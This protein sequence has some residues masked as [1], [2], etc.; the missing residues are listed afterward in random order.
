M[1]N[2]S[3]LHDYKQKYPFLDIVYIMDGDEK[4]HYIA[5]QDVPRNTK[6]TDTRYW[7]P[8]DIT[9]NDPDYANIRNKPT[10]NGVEVDGEM[11]SED[12]GVYSKP[13]NGIPES[14]LAPE[15]QTQ[16]NKHFKGWYDSEDNLPDNPMVGDY[17]YV[18]G[19]TAEDPVDIYE[20][21]MEGTW[22][23]SG[24][25]I[26]TSNVQTFQTGEAVNDVD[27]DDTHLSNTV[28][29]SLAKA[30]D[31]MPLKDKLQDITTEYV[32]V[33]PVTDGNEQNVFDGYVLVKSTNYPLTIPKI[34]VSSNCRHIVI[35]VEGYNS[36]RFL[37]R[38]TNNNNSDAGWAFYDSSNYSN[39]SFLTDNTGY[40]TY[41]LFD[42]DTTLSSATTKEYIVKIPENAKYLKLCYEF[43][44]ITPTNFY[45]YL[46]KGD[47]VVGKDY[48]DNI[49]VELQN[50]IDDIVGKDEK[51]YEIDNIINDTYFYTS[52]L[53]GM[54]YN[55]SSSSENGYSYDYSIGSIITKDV[56][57]NLKAEGYESIVITTNRSYNCYVTFL[58]KYKPSADKTVKELFEQGYL[59]SIHEE[60]NKPVI[61]YPNNKTIEIN[62]PKDCRYIFFT[63]KVYGVDSSSVNRLPTKITLVKHEHIDGVIDEINKRIY[64]L[65]SSTNELIIEH[66][67]LDNKGKVIEDA[68]K[69][70]TGFIPHS[71]GF[72]IELQDGY[73]VEKAMLYDTQGNLVNNLYYSMRSAFTTF[74]GNAKMLLQF[75]VRLVIS[76]SDNATIDTTAVV[77]RYFIL[78]DS[79]FHRTIPT[80]LRYKEMMYRLNQLENV[81]WYNE[82]S[83]NYITSNYYA[84]ATWV[85]IPYSEAGEYTKYVGMHVS[86]RTYLTAVLNK[87]SVLYTENIQSNANRSKYGLTYHGL[88]GLSGTY[89]G[90]VCSGLIA[91]AHGDKDITI[92]NS[93]TG[94]QLARGYRDENTGGTTIEIK[95]NGSWR[96]GTIDELFN[97]IEPLDYIWNT[98][99]ITIVSD[100][101]KDVYGDK[102]FF[103]WSEQ[104][105]PM[106]FST[107]FTKEM[108]LNRLNSIVNTLSN[109]SYKQ[110]AV[111]RKNDWANQ[112][113]MPEENS[114]DYIQT[115]F[116][117]YPKELTIDKDI[118]TFAGEYAAFSINSDDDNTSEYNNNKAFLNIHRGAGYDTLQIFD[119]DDEIL[120]TPVTVDISANSG[121]F[122]YNSSNI[123]SNDAS[124]KEDWIIVDLTQ[125]QTPLTHGKYKARVLNSNNS[126]IVS[127]FTHFQMVD[128]SFIVTK[129]VDNIETIFNSE[130]GTP[131]LIRQEKVDGMQLK[132]SI[133]TNE[134]V[135]LGSKTLNWT[136]DNLYKYVKLFVKADYGVIVKRIDISL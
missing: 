86:L 15:V 42:C 60:T 21:T 39:G 73:R 131:Y 125:L 107:P 133:L 121:T 68:T 61:I 105:T 48:V 93:T 110:W 119:E 54:F 124:D 108:F 64:T 38:L 20:C 65:T 127:G 85:G 41:S 18:K 29:N 35:D 97:L 112:P 50:D 3:S 115:N 76:R 10:I 59:C 44:Q 66:G 100:V 103:V 34:Y 122:I 87:R 52:N 4:V 116:F 74:Y 120:D 90:T 113:D 71:G 117:D 69:L 106:S 24:R 104:T 9:G 134:D 43:V 30:I 96:N 36:V 19:A 55:N 135:T 111:Y 56:V 57:A 84:P 53:V 88:S 49:K 2:N 83:L 33:I 70:V 23:D 132:S 26:D 7:Q 80:D 51:T 62:I 67:S 58:K 92:A 8:V 123:Y 40:I 79:R 89:Y 13:D 72:Y 126:E 102:Q 91:Y 22:S 6:I 5:K 14:D 129:N 28:T 25:T 98:G 63:K 32:K 77:K 47:T 118:S 17:A 16:L 46:K 95:E 109:G 45:C 78:A 99:H 114:N 136:A 11:T 130:E 81:V 27:I 101:Y 82:T 37:G 31:V 1:E 75:M 12:L 94:E 128:I